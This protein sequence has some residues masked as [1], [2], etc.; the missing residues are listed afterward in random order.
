M[1]PHNLPVLLLLCCI[2][3][4]ACTDNVPTVVTEGEKANAPNVIG[5]DNEHLLKL[6]VPSLAGWGDLSEIRLSMGESLELLATLETMGGLPLADEVLYLHSKT[7]NF[8][9][10]NQLVTSDIGQASSVLLAT[11][12]GRDEVTITYQDGLYTRLNVVVNEAQTLTANDPNIPKLE[13]LPGVLSWSTLAQVQYNDDA[14]V[15]P[16]FA[17]EIQALNGQEVKVQ[18][19]MLPLENAAN[20]THFILS[21]YPPS[22]FY[23]LPAGPEG[24]IE[25]Y[26]QQSVNF[27]FEPLLL[28]GKLTVLN[29]DEM[30]IFY[31]IENAQPVSL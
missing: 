20:Q 1:R 18:G 2:N 15:P 4:M 5:Q 22:C 8:F 11:V 30:G 16:T 25:I 7:G 31:R 26:S 28:S 24:I 29:N 9:T 21:V 27:S 14:S 6:A 19:F 10:Q 13:E 23:C 3:M 12:T 17:D